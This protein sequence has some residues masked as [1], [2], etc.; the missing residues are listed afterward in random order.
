MGGSRPVSSSGPWNFEVTGVQWMLHCCWCHQM[1]EK[2]WGGMPRG[3]MG[4]SSGVWSRR[5][6]G[7]QEGKR[8][9]F[10]VDDLKSCRHSDWWTCQMQGVVTT[11]NH[12]HNVGGMGSEA[13]LRTESARGHGEQTRQGGP[14][15]RSLSLQSA[16]EWEAHNSRFCPWS[17][18]TT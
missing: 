16:R 2:S 8:Y 12:T 3:V 7:H 14:K 13:G 15:V 4:C 17:L 5:D 18:C 10:I 6:L 9:V 11:A 1:M